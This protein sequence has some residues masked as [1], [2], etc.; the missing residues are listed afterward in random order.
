M[1]MSSFW[2]SN[3][4]NIVS[5]SSA[6]VAFIG[7]VIASPR[8][9]RMCNVF[10]TKAE[11]STNYYQIVNQFVQERTSWQETMVSLQNTTA[12]LRAEM[13]VFKDR[14]VRVESELER[15]IPKYRAA[16]HFIHDLRSHIVEKDMPSTPLLLER[17]L[18]QIHNE[19]KV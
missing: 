3:F 19:Y 15:L 7:L 13:V 12:A 5:L 10:K 1:I 6:A 18:E 17:D 11:L 8:I 16:L 4:Q 2:A 14:L 9:K